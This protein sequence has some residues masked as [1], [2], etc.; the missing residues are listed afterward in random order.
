LPT[1]ES[2]LLAV[3]SVGNSAAGDLGAALETSQPE[4][5]GL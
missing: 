3:A 4:A 5:L 1:P 2:L